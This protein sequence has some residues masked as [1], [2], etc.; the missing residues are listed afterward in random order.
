MGMEEGGKERK[1]GGKWGRQ[2]QEYEK[3]AAMRPE[4]EKTKTN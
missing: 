3:A 1:R 4:T 2:R